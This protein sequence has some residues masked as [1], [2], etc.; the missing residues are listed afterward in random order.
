VLFELQ[1][2]ET[3]LRGVGLLEVPS[4]LA[5][6]GPP[7]LSAPSTQPR[8][9]MPS[10][11]TP[12]GQGQIQHQPHHGQGHRPPRHCTYCNKDGHTWAS[13]YTR[14]PSLR[15][16]SQARVQSGS[17]GSSA[18]ALS[19]QDI[20]RSLRGMLATLGSSSVGTTSSVTDSSGTA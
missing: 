3:H 19:D 7:L 1:T 16:R 2:E 11:P 9:S 8:S 18:V 6:H 10:V 17:L 15:P 14:D 5:A 12:P 4:V 13:C 20:I